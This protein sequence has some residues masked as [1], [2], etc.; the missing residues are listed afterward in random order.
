MSDR[1]RFATRNNTSFPDESSGFSGFPFSTISQGPK[2][3]PNDYHDFTLSDGIEFIW[4]VRKVQIDVTFIVAVDNG[5]FTDTTTGA[6]SGLVD[7]FASNATENDIWKNFDN[8][9]IVP[10]ICATVTVHGNGDPDTHG[11]NGGSFRFFNFRYYE[12]QL[13]MD[14]YMEIDGPTFLTATTGILAGTASLIGVEVDMFY[15]GV[16]A[17]GTP[18]VSIVVTKGEYWP[19][20]AADG[21]PIYSTT[22]GAQLQSPTN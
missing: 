22:T 8:S 5:G 21:S 7:L 16:P 17:V 13:A 2:T 9:A 4:R 18:S 14:F 19:Y 15:V 12:E 6:F 3:S 10:F 1:V 20:A 11:T